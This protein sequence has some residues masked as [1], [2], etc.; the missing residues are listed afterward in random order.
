[1][2]DGSHNADT[3]RTLIHFENLDKRIRVFYLPTNY[4]VIFHRNFALSQAK[5]QYIAIHD[6]DDIMPHDRLQISV[7]YF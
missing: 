6:D 5:G 4:G 2:D 1:M 7:E 3:L